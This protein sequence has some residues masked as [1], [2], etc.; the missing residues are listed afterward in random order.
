[1]LTPLTFDQQLALGGAATHRREY[2][3]APRLRSGPCAGRTA[4]RGRHIRVTRHTAD[5]LSTGR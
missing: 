5:Q 3:R 4:R 2:P 1:M